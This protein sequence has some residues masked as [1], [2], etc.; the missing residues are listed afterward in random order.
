M[1][2]ELLKARCVR[3]EHVLAWPGD[4]RAQD[5]CPRCSEGLR[6]HV[7]WFGEMPYYLEVEI[8]R[9]L[10]AEVFVS[11]GTSG[12]VYP[13]AGMVQ[14]VTSRGGLTVELNLEPSDNFDLFGH[15]VLGPAGTVVPRFVALLGGSPGSPPV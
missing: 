12:T 15:C 14:E 5:A 1:H 8:P 2:G 11:I 6:P 4:I 10:E 9:A 7:V 13:A 3:C